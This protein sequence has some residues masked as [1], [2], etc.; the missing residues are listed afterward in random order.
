MLVSQP[1][2]KRT[3]L[4]EVQLGTI[5]LQKKI[6]LVY[7]SELDNI[8]M[9]GLVATSATQTAASPSAN[10]VVS[11]AGL[12]S[13]LLTLSVGDDEQ[14]YNYPMYNLNPANVSGMIQMFDNKRINIPKS[15]VTIIS[16]SNL[17]NNDSVMLNWI[18]E[19][20]AK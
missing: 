7:N 14:I 13:L 4:F 19:R 9:Y 11:N 16:T 6:N 20:L 12:A 15:Y 18:F 3:Y 2:A 5:A 17:N 10:A 8:A 1:I